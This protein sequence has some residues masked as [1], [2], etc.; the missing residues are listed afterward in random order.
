[1]FATTMVHICPH[2]GSE[3]L[4]KNGHTQR[5]AQRAR[6]LDCRCTFTLAP[7]GPRHSEQVKAQVLAA[8]QDRMEQAIQAHGAPAFLHNNNGPEFI[9]KEV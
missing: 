4:Q 9:A 8:H 2:R 6:C 3:R 5:G 7:K 1:M